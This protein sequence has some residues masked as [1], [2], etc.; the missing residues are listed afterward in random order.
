MSQGGKVSGKVF[1]V[2]QIRKVFRFVKPFRK[3]FY[4]TIVST[5][6]LSGLSIVRPLLFKD[7]VNHY[8]LP[9][10][11]NGITHISLIILFMLFA[12]AL[13]QFANTYLANWL[14]QNIIRDIRAALFRHLSHYRLRYF[15]RTP[16]GTIVTRIVSDIEAIA[17]IFSQGFVVILGD[18][19]TLLVYVVVMLW[20]N[21]KVA[22]II[23]LSIPLLLVATWIFKNAIKHTFQ[24]V[25]TQ[26]ARLNAFV[27]EHV[28]GMKIVQIF[29]REKQEMNKFRTINAAHRDA[30]IRAVFAYSV[31]FPVVEMLSALS[32]A[33]LVWYGG[34]QM[35]GGAIDYGEVTFFVMLIYMM[36]RPI[37]ML[38][39]RVNT[40]QMGIVASERVF[41]IL[42]VDDQTP[43]H[44]SVDAASIKGEIEYKDLWF[45][46]AEEDFVLKGISFRA[47]PGETIA[48]VGATGSGK[49]S[50]IN[51][52]GRFYD[53]QQGSIS[54]DGIAIESYTL[55]SLRKSIGVVLQD[56]FLFSDSI[57]NNI[58][59]N[60]P[61]ITKEEVIEAAKAVGAHDFI[62][63]L[64]GGYD[65]QV[66]ERGAVLSVGQRQLIAFI[67]AYVYKPRILILDEATSSIDTESEIMI[68]KAT[69]KITEGR[70]SVIIAHRLATV[71]KADLILVLDHGK[72]LES[73]KHQ[74]LLKQNGQYKKLFE[75]QFKEE[76]VS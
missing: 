58:T 75:L 5:V 39:D 55:A 70:T 31:F 33:L 35:Y 29:T 45:A 59:L 66:Q 13:L 37:R 25:R 23:M 61:E 67:R 72:I 28:T 49:S 64:P 19:L 60:N 4:L 22:L 9:K 48:L 50:I 74:E 6:M 3:I 43:D 40:L 57:V 51:L 76:P 18:L 54:I 12:E 71:Q 2:E 21:W 7:V 8:I 30:N 20:V 38:A 65:Y 34:I 14:G 36:F 69:E 32:L 16:I 73:G 42:D 41:K 68:R 24:D 47:R 10:D 53:Y 1:D 11:I 44:G 27:Q 17:D 26:V 62:A 56:V 15:D 63:S 52:M 46:Y